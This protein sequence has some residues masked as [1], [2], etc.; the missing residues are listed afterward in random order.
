M[1]AERVDAVVIGAG[2]NGLSAAITLAE[3]G[4]DVVV[5]EAA[6]TPGGAVR[7]EELTQPGFAHD[8]FSAVYPAGAASPVFAR[9]PLGEH[10]LEWVHPEVAMA[11]PLPD[12]SAV[13]LHRDPEATAA[14]LDAQAPG[15][16]RGW[17]DLVGPL[18]SACPALRRTL[19]SGWLPVRGPVGLLA[20]LGVGRVLELARTA[21]AP[22]TVLADERFAARGSRA[23]LLG[24]VHHGDVPADEA[25]SAMT[26]L[27][28]QLL[29]HAVG[30]PS[31]RGGAQSLTNAL[32][33]YLQSL[34]GQVRTATRAEAVISRQGRVAGVHTADGQQLR[35][36]V[37]VADTTP[38]TVLALAGERALGRRYAR[39]LRRYRFGPG[40]VKIDWALDAPVPW[41]APEARGAGTVHVGGLPEEILQASH[42]VR[43]G[44]LPAQPFLLAGQQSLADPSRAPQGGHT[45]WAY[46]RVPRGLDWSTGANAFLEAIEAQIERFAPGF[47]DVARARHVLLPPDFAARNAN[48]SEGDVGTG[49]L[50]LDQ[51]AFR[52]VPTLAPYRTPLAGLYLGSAATF[53]GPAVHGVCGRAAARLALAESRLRWW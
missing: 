32:V 29:G 21:L 47:A 15:D 46:T 16:G 4:R 37:V 19:L 34:G 27:Y 17:L 51:V 3:A 49:T 31:P 53:P 18:L 9:W 43:Q 1:T 48:L 10:G 23:W 12:G 6:D 30:W 33:G 2:P 5:C 45:F 22:A 25:G 13:A 52:P 26:G 36:D 11:H 28:L 8:T 24:S 44:A 39:A 40:T 35:A 7:T 50:A 20:R 14:S 38:Q 41:R 42:T